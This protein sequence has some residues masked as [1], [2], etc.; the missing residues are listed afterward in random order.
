MPYSEPVKPGDPVEN[1]RRIARLA[2]MLLDMRI[3]Y[4]RRPRPDILA[5]IQ[6]RARE[7]YE[8]AQALDKSETIPAEDALG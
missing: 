5:Q 2:Q 3:E 1:V 7:L 6:E 8:F 4:E